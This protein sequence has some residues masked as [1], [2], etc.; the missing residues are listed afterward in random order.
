[1]TG[2][3]FKP[4]ELRLHHFEKRGSNVHVTD[5]IKRAKRALGS[6]ARGGTCRPGNFLIADLLRSLLV[7]FRSE[8]ARVGRPTANVV[9]VFETF[10]RSHNL[11]AWLRFAP[12]RGN[13]F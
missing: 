2:N 6:V 3:G 9:I 8:T 5:G 13:F 1:M 4:G 11:K 12:R 10:K 7:P